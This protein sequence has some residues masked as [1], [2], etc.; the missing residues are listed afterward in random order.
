MKWICYKEL[1]E[2]LKESLTQ[3]LEKFLVIGFKTEIKNLAILY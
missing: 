1:N 3:D 2:E